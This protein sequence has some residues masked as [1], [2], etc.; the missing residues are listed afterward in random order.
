MK[1]R[2]RNSEDDKNR[3]SKYAVKTT[4]KAKPQNGITK[5][6]SVDGGRFV[7]HTMNGLYEEYTAIDRQIRNLRTKQNKIKKELNAM[8]WFNKGYFEKPFYIYVLEL[9]NGHYYIGQSR[10]PDKRFKSHIEGKGAKWTK[11]HKAIRI[12]ETRT[13]E[14]LVESEAQLFEDEVTLEYAIKYCADKVRGG[15]YTQVENVRWPQEVLDAEAIC[16]HS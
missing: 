9:E 13:T 11:Q 16:S 12:V 5:V 10:N 8:G 2:I 4:R 15:G 3:F 14:A 7:S 1:V 6:V